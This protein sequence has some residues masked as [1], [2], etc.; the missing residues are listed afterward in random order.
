MQSA[1]P[2]ASPTGRVGRRDVVRSSGSLF[3]KS[4]GYYGEKTDVDGC[5][6]NMEAAMAARHGSAYSKRGPPE[7]PKSHLTTDPPKLRFGWDC[8][9]EG[10]LEKGQ[11][12]TCSR[13]KTH[14]RKKDKA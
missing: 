7:A 5:K 1:R 6:R 8:R 4:K 13:S 12:K 2:A 10:V 9:T 11:R 14:R 3:L